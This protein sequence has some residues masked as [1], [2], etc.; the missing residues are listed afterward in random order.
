MKLKRVSRLSPN[1]SVWFE[2][3]KE[4]REAQIE[5]KVGGVYQIRFKDGST[6]LVSR[7]AIV[8]RS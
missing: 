3:G 8:R 1:A 4:R 6:R 2:E 5:N 7:D